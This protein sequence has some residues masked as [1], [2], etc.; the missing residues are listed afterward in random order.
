MSGQSTNE[1]ETIKEA[2]KLK[3]QGV[4]VFAIGVGSGPRQSELQGMAT[5]NPKSHVFTVTN[6]NALDRIKATLQQ[7]T[8]EGKFLWL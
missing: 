5:P 2:N 8:C 1:Q 7:K 3:G 4:T 6:Y